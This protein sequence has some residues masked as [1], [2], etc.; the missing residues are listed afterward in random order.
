[1]RKYLCIVFIVLVLC[2]T[3]IVHAENEVSN[4]TNTTNATNSTNET[5]TDLQTQQQQLQEQIEQ[6]NQELSNTQ[7]ELSENLQEVEK[8]DEKISTS[9]AELQKLNEQVETLKASMKQIEDELN[10]VT[11]KYEKQKKV[12]EKRVVALYETGEIDY[13]DIL[14]N[15]NS[16]SE[17]VS[18]YYVIAEITEADNELLNDIAEKKDTIALSKEKLE[19]EKEELASLV[20]TQQRTSK[21]LQN[22]KTIRE[23][24]ISKLSDEEKEKQAQIDEMT[25]QYE[26]VNRQILEL[27]E[28]GLDTQ[29]IGGELAWPVPGYTKITSKYGMRVH[30]ITGQ[31]KLHTGVD[32]GAPTG[33]NFIAA[34]DGIVVKSEYN[35]AYGRMVIIDHGGGISTLYAHGSE[36]LVEVGQT[37]K[38]GDAVLKVGSSGYSTGPHAH[39]EVRINGVVT[40]PMPY[41]T[42]GIVPGSEQDEASQ[43]KPS[44]ENTIDEY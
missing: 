34:N 3:T 43:N 2:Y 19:N 4:E 25:K 22:T 14:L 13:L 23:S 17:F 7:S 39:F 12:F 8:L 35:T 6:A 16:V 42:N 24:Y 29:Y 20:E 11:E 31:Y 1:M 44:G 33:A 28:Q 30:P 32:I 37:V 5:G 36:F 38:R 10:E 18:S 27:A 15:S 26:E 40:D 21:I 9:E 41:I